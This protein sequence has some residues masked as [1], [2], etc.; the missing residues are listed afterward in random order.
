VSGEDSGSPW[1]VPLADIAPGPDVVAA[2]EEAVASGWWSMGPRVA[3]F[4]EAFAAFCE[5]T[6]AFAVANGTAALQLALAAVGCGPGDEVVLPSLSF[7]AAAN[8]VVLAGATPVFC[9]ITSD[10]DLNLEPADLVGRLGP[11]TKAVIVLHYGGLP[12][13]IDVVAAAC[14][15]RGIRVIEDAAHAIG[16]RWRGRH[17]GA[18]GNATAFSFH[19]S[20]NITT[21]EGGALAVT[22]Q[23]DAD[24]ARRLSMHGLDRSAWSRHESASPAGYDVLEPGTKCVMTDVAAAVG[25]RQLDR[26]DG[27]IERRAQLAAAYDERLSALPLDLPPHA[28][29]DARHAHHLYMVRVRDDA[30]A[31]RDAVVQG[32]HDARIGTTI[33]FT[34][35]HRFTFYR[36]RY[37][38]RPEDFPAAEERGRRVV[39]LPLFP[40]MEESDVDDVATAL[41]RLLG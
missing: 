11:R 41:G 25:L 15:E 35:I 19:A 7:V 8:A 23:A 10:S 20:K 22:S 33:H 3:A 37:G 5:T 1:A 36:T 26:L 16:A 6:H 38:L 31:D 18:H 24:R 39:S 32:L 9:D 13:E 21:F 4:E 2:V 29:E 34:P 12:C 14:A 28:P 27:W 30:P 17:V 40:A